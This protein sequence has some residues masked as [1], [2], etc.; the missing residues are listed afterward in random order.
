MGKV[1]SW[2]LVELSYWCKLTFLPKILQY[3]N[4]YFAR[5]EIQPMWCQVELNIEKLRNTQKTQKRQKTGI[6]KLSFF[7]FLMF[8]SIW[9]EKE[10]QID[11]T[12]DFRVNLVFLLNRSRRKFLRKLNC[13]VF[14]PGFCFIINRS[15]ITNCQNTDDAYSESVYFNWSVKFIV[16]NRTVLSM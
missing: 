10:N 13:T 4:D 16:S 9:D 15:S 2:W 6:L 1:S 7:T 11:D 8:S 3:A 12:L 5:G 14:I